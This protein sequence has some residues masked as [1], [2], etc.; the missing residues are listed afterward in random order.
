M[1]G[2]PDD[3]LTFHPS[4]PSPLGSDCEV[5]ANTVGSIGG[6]IVTLHEV[7]QILPPRAGEDF[8]VTCTP[9]D[10]YGHLVSHPAA[11]GQH[12][13]VTMDGKV[14]HYDLTGF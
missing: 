11:N 13:L 6:N 9:R 5:P 8:I 7:E 14:P 2:A 12:Y 1:V 10:A 4:T 3:L